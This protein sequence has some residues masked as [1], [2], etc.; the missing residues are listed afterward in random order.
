MQDF[1]DT[2]L[3]EAES[4]SG[5]FSENLNLEA[6]EGVWGKDRKVI[7]PGLR[8]ARWRQSKEAAAGLRQERALPVILRTDGQT[9][10]SPRGGS[11]RRTSS[12]SR[13]R[14]P[15]P[16]PG[17]A[18]AEGTSLRSGP[19][20][21]EVSPASAPPGPP[22]GP[23]TRLTLGALADVSGAQRGQE[24][25]LSWRSVKHRAPVLWGQAESG[26]RAPAPRRLPVLWS[27]RTARHL[28]P[29]QF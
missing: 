20:G 8:A 23:Q 3:K 11:S 17:R 12:C 13:L 27:R 10:R 21:D 2:G 9:D 5:I 16:A 24:L 18:A 26:V 1:D 22:A 7:H 25:A 15:A 6:C 19:R 14:P 4:S 29:P 28:L